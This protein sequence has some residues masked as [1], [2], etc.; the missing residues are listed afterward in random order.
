MSAHDAILQKYQ[1]AKNTPS[2]INEHVPIF[3]DM[4][5]QSNSILELG[6]RS[7][8]S[9]WGFLQGL[10]DQSEVSEKTLTCCDIVK[11]KNVAILEKLAIEAGVSFKFIEGNDLQVDLPKADIVFIDTWHIYGQLKREL[12]KV[13]DLAQKYILLHDT[14][15]DGVYGETIRNKWDAFAQSQKSGIPVHEIN[16]GLWPAVEEFLAD[17]KNYV[18]HKR[19]TNNNGLT[20]LKRVN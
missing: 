15:I 12:Q 7:V 1:T 2:D 11:S 5:S 16:L 3:R 17:N 6:V 18:L 19:H 13:K 20:I 4:A 8:V 9:S 14:T 10:L